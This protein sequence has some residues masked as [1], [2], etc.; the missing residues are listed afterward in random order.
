VN[1]PVDVTSSLAAIK[2]TMADLHDEDWINDVYLQITNPDARGNSESVNDVINRQEDLVT[3]YS[4]AL[5]IVDQ[6]VPADL[7]NKAGRGLINA[8]PSY[9]DKIHAATAH[10]FSSTRSDFTTIE[11]IAKNLRRDLNGQSRKR[12]TEVLTSD[13][14]LTRRHLGKDDVDRE[15]RSSVS[16]LHM[17]ASVWTPPPGTECNVCGDTLHWAN[18]CPSKDKPCYFCVMANHSAVTYSHLRKAKSRARIRWCL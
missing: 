9:E 12:K 7:E 6:P 10:M 18:S 17:Q 4:L 5:F 1:N 14:P 16:Q 8:L 13:Q 15:N 2:E 3:V 11:R